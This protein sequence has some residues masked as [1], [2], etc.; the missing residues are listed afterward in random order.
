M[1]GGSERRCLNHSPGELEKSLQIS[2]PG[3][4]QCFKC[5]EHAV[6]RES[7]HLILVM[8]EKENKRVELLK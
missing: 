2:S 5:K 8:M 4:K 1:Q 7:V 6:P 3:L